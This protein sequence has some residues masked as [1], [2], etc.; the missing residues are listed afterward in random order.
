MPKIIMSIKIKHEEGTTG[1]RSTFKEE[2][3]K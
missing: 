3:H 2:M 1:T